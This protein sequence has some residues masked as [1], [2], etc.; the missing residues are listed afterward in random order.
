MLAGL[1]VPVDAGGWSRG[2]PWGEALSWAV[3]RVD[4]GPTLLAM[5]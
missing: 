3:Q 4:S 5:H 1:A 2:Q